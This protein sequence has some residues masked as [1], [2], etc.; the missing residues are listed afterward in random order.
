MFANSLGYF[1]FLAATLLVFYLLPRPCKTPMLLLASYGFYALIDWRMTL[2]LLSMTT[3]S[4]SFTQ[5][6]L[7]SEG[8][9]ANGWKIAAVVIPVL[10]LAV[11]KYLH[12]FADSVISLFHLPSD[13]LELQILLP[14]G[15]SFYAFHCI[16]YTMDAYRG[17]VDQE[18]S[19]GEYALYVAFFPKLLS[20]PIARP[21]DFIG[22]I[23]NWQ[24]PDENFLS[25]GFGLILLGLLK[26]CVFAD[27]FAAATATYFSAMPT[28]GWLTAWISTFGFTLQLYF[29]FSGYSDIAIGSSLLF[30][31]RL[32]QNFLRPYLSLDVQEFWR[33]WH[34]SL[35][36]W[37]RDYLYIPM[38]GNR[39][40]ELKTC[41][42]L[43][44]TMLIGGLWHGAS[45]SFVVWGG[46]H[47]FLL[48]LLRFLR[49]K[50]KG[51]VPFWR[52]SFPAR[53]I[54]GLVTFLCVSLAWVFFKASSFE[55]AIAI[56]RQM[57]HFG[58]TGTQP[59]TFFHWILVILAAFGMVLEEF[60][61]LFHRI[62]NAPDLVR[63]F[64]AVLVLYALVFFH[65]TDVQ[66]P[67]LYF[68]F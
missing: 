17:K 6:M 8:R 18:V 54:S 36:S 65:I 41:R 15:I 31:L 21:A 19:L 48:V 64:V 1:V 14:A 60:K 42:N 5:E 30:G 22:Q 58:T 53:I 33:R 40:G 61:G 62:I 16:S 9:S 55:Q 43:F 11:F 47:G 32:P 29:D 67:F 49:P 4:Y 39:G 37:L 20:G 38:G 57:F 12:F 2:L 3:L 68:T 7:R 23:R 34:I 51:V 25:E 27:N 66:I 50:T 10:T 52:K 13:A 56:L 24:R 46:I 26:K 45:W 59:F 44:L 35:S 63:A 28:E